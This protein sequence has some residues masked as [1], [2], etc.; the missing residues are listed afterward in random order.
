MVTYKKKIRKG[1]YHMPVIQG[2]AYWSKHIRADKKFP[3]NGGGI[4][5]IDVSNLTK[6]TRDELKKLGLSKAIKNKDDDREFFITLRRNEIQADKSTRNDPPE[7]VDSQNNSFKGA[8]G[9]GSD[10]KVRFRTYDYSGTND[11]GQS[12]EGTSAELLK[13][14]VIDLV[15]YET[16][17]KEDFESMED[18]FEVVDGGFVATEGTDDSDTDDDDVPF[19]MDEESVA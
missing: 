14:Q 13:I 5:S 9:N 18:D 16:D 3:K 15:P 11:E 2:K 12:F 8:I 4:W 10:V 7:A 17:E 1:K 19:D 6:E